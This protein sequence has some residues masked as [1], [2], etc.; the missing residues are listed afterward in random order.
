MANRNNRTRMSFRAN[1]K[2]LSSCFQLWR[3]FVEGSSK[4]RKFERK[5]NKPT[6]SEESMAEP[7][8]KRSRVAWSDREESRLI[9]EVSINLNFGRILKEYREDFNDCRT[10]KSLEAHYYRMKRKGLV[11]RL[12]QT[13]PL[14]SNLRSGGA[15]EKVELIPYKIKS[16]SKKS[17]KSKAK[18]AKT[19]ES[20]NDEKTEQEPEKEKE[21]EQQQIETVS[22]SNQSSSTEIDMEVDSPETETTCNN[23]HEGEKVIV[24]EKGDT[25][26][27]IDDDN[28]DLKED[29]EAEIN[30]DESLPSPHKTQHIACA[31][32]DSNDKSESIVSPKK[33]LLDIPPSSPIITSSITPPPTP[34]S[35][36]KEIDIDTDDNDGNNYE[37]S[38]N[39]NNDDEDHDD[40]ITPITTIMEHNSDI[41]QPVVVLECMDETSLRDHIISLRTER[42]WRGCRQI[43]MTLM[44]HPLNKGKV[45]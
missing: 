39:D 21:K 15:A 44:K 41:K 3:T 16:G 4:K 5:R 36:K 38:N 26:M 18:K 6:P 1:T 34:P 11:P 9:K 12:R 31:P 23:F 22:E 33:E 43:L 13:A 32:E 42:V 28:E 35:I 10:A 45:K 7:A 40:K 37:N 19:E 2:V 29:D 25:N 17:K 27:D 8:S 20:D 24:E 14:R 30:Q